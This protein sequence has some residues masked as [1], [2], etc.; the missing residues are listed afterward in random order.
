[1]ADLEAVR[2]QIQEVVPFNR[3]LGVRVVAV[4]AE[5]AEVEL[6]ATPE[7]LNHV[8]TMHAAAQFGLGESA[9]GALSVAAFADLLAS[10][11]IPLLAEARIVYHRPASGTLRA[12]ATLPR[13]EQER[14]RAD[15]AATGKARYE[16]PVQ[17]TDAAG[18]VTTTLQAN[19]VVLRPR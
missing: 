15:F 19:W 12:R 8:G 9:S 13:A 3:V 17:I 6:A 7:R 16:L 11:A 5:S 2:R 1:M 18:T 4:E 14:V 10:G